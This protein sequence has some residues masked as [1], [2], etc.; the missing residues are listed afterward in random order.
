MIEV[1]K[2]DPSFARYFELPFTTTI[3]NKIELYWWGLNYN[4]KEFA[5][6]IIK[7]EVEEITEEIISAAMILRKE[8]KKRNLSYAD[9]T[10]YAFAQ[11][12]GL[13]FLTGDRQFKDLAGVEFVQ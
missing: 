8:H 11:K 6:K 4:S 12:K 9:A 3:L 5:D 1:I 7:F 13:L 10:G 2:K